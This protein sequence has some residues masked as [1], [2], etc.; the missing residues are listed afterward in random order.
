MK[1]EVDE[2]GDLDVIDSD[3]GLVPRCDNQVPLLCPLQL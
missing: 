2:L 3:L 1:H